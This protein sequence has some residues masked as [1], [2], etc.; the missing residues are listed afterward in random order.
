MGIRLAER[1]GRF[2]RNLSGWLL[3]AVTAAMV[4]AV[5]A[6]G[7]F[8]QAAQDA[9]PESFQRSFP[10]SAGGTL[11]VENRKGT[12]HVTGSD[13]NQVVVSVRKIFEGGSE[14][15]RQWWMAESK[16][17]FDSTTSHLNVRVEYPSWN[18]VFCANISDEVDLTIAVPRRTNVE[19]EGTRP[20]MEVASIDGNIR[21][22]SNRSPIE[23]KSTRGAIRIETNRG[24]V[25]LSDVA[26]TGRLGLTSNRAEAEIDAKSLA[27]EVDLETERG[28]IALRIPST[29]GV[30]LDYVGGRRASFHC[31]F[32]VT[33]NQNG[34]ELNEVTGRVGRQGA[35]I[36]GA[37]NQG[38]PRMILR[39]ERGSI[40]IE[41]GS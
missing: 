18:C 39:T 23:I 17:S 31:D 5:C 19:L 7:V 38:G 6:P 26:I 30:N 4:L 11:V 12:I 28:S 15:E 33:T 40:S 32:P 41:K 14:K 27:G 24:N 16:V 36:S 20:D 22:S 35:R 21:I 1:E 29:V 25:R 9:N 2:S 8:A 10:M 37:L 34:A 13:T 3:A